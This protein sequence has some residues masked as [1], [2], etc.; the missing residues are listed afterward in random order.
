MEIFNCFTIDNGDIK[1]TICKDKV[2]FLVVEEIG[3]RK[4]EFI[5]EFYGF[6]S[7]DCPA[8]NPS[9]DISRDLFKYVIDPL[10]NNGPLIFNQN[11]FFKF[12]KWA[13]YQSNF[14]V[15]RGAHASKILRTILGVRIFRSDIS[16]KYPYGYFP[17]T[18]EETFLNILNKING[19]KFLIKKQ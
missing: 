14:H 13:T 6:L 4:K 1:Y 12:G 18:L 16:K 7:P 3:N 11:L 15:C 8:I 2:K 10:E 19:N 17:L 9:E 5:D